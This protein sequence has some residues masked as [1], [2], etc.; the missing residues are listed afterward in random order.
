M[1]TG[2][3]PSEDKL[4]DGSDDYLWDRSGEPDPEIQKLEAML[5]KVQSNR[6]RPVLPGKATV[7]KWS[8][9]QRIRLVPVLAAVLAIAAIGFVTYAA[10]EKR[11]R[12]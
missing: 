8:I 3:N 11:P 1:D 4:L 5:G 10:Q 6:P 12:P 9:L 7:S 2:N